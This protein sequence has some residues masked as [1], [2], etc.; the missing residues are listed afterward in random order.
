MP[1]DELGRELR[2]LLKE[3]EQREP[4]NFNRNSDAG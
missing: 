4:N 1:N 2:E 3:F